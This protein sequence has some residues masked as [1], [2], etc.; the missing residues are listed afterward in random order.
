MSKGLATEFLLNVLRTAD[1]KQSLNVNG[2]KCPN[3]TSKEKLWQAVMPMLTKVIPTWQFGRLFVLFLLHFIKN[4]LQHWMDHIRVTSKRGNTVM[5]QFLDKL[6]FALLN[7]NFLLILNYKLARLGH[8]NWPKVVL[9]IFTELVEDWEPCKTHIEIRTV[10]LL[11]TQNKSWP[12]V[13]FKIA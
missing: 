12:I 5:T 10:T 6:F 13:I 9:I 7:K 2:F 11:E 8:S 1:N 3:K 4:I